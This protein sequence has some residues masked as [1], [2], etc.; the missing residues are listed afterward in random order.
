MAYCFRTYRD[1][2]IIAMSAVSTDRNTLPQLHHGI[3]KLPSTKTVIKFPPPHLQK[4]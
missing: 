4:H 3:S 1:R 2:C